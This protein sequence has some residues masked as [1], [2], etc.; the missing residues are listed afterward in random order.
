MAEPVGLVVG[1]IGLAGLFSTCVD[2][3]KLVEVY[4]SRSEDYDL[5]QTML[6]NQQFS[7]MAWGKA[8]GFMDPDRMN[9]RYVSSRR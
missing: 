7:F 2:S 5:L 3:F 6:D 1:F 4:N 9:M 8:C